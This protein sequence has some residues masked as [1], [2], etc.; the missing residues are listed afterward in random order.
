LI[1]AGIGILLLYL[2]FGLRTV[3]LIYIVGRLSAIIYQRTKESFTYFLNFRLSKSLS[4]IKGGLPFLFIGIFTTIYFRIDTVMLRYMGGFDV[5]GWYNAAYR[6]IDLLAVIPGIFLTATFPLFVKMYAQK[7]QS[8]YQKLFKKTFKYLSV[9]AVPMLIIGIIVAKDIIKLFYTDSFL[10]SVLALQILLISGFL[11]FI[12]YLLLSILNTQNKEKIVLKIT[13]S[14][15]LLNIIL[16]L[17]L[18]PKYSLYGAAA[19]TALTEIFN[20]GAAFIYSRLKPNYLELSKTLLAAI[21]MV[22]FLVAF[23]NLNVIILSIL[24]LVLYS[25]AI[26]LIKV[27]TKDEIK[28]YLSMIKQKISP[29][30]TTID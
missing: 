20:L 11:I 30:L 1:E 16:N 5:V 19:A 2:G 13:G 26:L 9:I 22:V 24:S 29:N 23:R 6:F 10:P 28:F 15:A 4:I 17:I 25:A 21:P 3:L 14:A 18:I 7:E 27:V 8:E 12:N